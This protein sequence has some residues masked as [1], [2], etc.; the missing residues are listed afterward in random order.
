MLDP[1]ASKTQHLGAVEE[2]HGSNM[3]QTAWSTTPLGRPVVQVGYEVPPV[4]V[5]CED[6]QAFGQKTVGVGVMVGQFLGIDFP[7]RFH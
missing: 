5:L 1:V 4:H 7:E 6:P 3:L 2:K